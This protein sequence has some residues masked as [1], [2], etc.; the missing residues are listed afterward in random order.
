MAEKRRASTPEFKAEASSLIVGALALA[1]ERRPPG[2]GLLARSDRSSQ[3]ASDDY[4][5]L[6][7]GHGITRSISRRADC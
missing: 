3:Y 5:S 6:L 4:R 1:V 7:A 2:Q